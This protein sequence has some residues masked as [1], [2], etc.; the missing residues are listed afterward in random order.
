MGYSRGS[1]NTEA[2]STAD[3]DNEILTV[4]LHMKQEAR[5]NHKTWQQKMKRDSPLFKLSELSPPTNKEIKPNVI[6]KSNTT[7]IFNHWEVSNDLKYLQ[8]GE[9]HDCDI[10]VMDF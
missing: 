7:C 10:D 4:N 1:P 9:I 3:T 5:I 6:N 2:T 8:E